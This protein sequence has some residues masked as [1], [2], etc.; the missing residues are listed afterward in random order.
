MNKNRIVKWL[1][2]MAAMFLILMGAQGHGRYG[3]ISGDD[4][5][6]IIASWVFFIAGLLML[7]PVFD[8]FVFKD[9]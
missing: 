4:V 2:L 1:Y 7:V 3:T 5:F 8:K 6:M 9:D